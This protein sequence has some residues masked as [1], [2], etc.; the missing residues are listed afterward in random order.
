MG[1]QEVMDGRLPVRGGLWIG[2]HLPPHVGYGIARLFAGGIAR[3][4]PRIYWK[5]RRN[6]RQV[7]GPAVT[8]EE[9]HRMTWQV[10]YHAGQTYYDF[11]RAVG[12][13]QEVL[14][15]AVQIP[16]SFIDLAYAEMALGRGVLFLGVHMSNFDL[17]MLS[18][19]ARDVP[20]LI[21]SLGEGQTGFALLNELRK[22]GNLEVMALGP[23]SLRVAIDRLKSGGAVITGADRPV[24]GERDLVEFFGRPAYLPLGP[25]RL[26]LMTEATV[27]VGAPYWAPEQGYMLDYTGPIE[28]VH[29]GSR[30]QD[31]LDNTRRLGKVMESYIRRRPTQWMMFHPVWP[32][33]DEAAA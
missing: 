20:A 19:G 15:Q 13:P 10:F 11:F 25:A 32:D 2:Q 7:V 5:V 8:D 22:V 14:A 6:L 12:Q 31:I 23:E 3:W 18:L 17:G 16:D 9:I 26:A 29:T 4:K 33:G 21:L 28:M 27:I 30:R 1:F 24:P